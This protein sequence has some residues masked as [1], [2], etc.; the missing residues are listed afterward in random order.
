MDLVAYYMDIFTSDEQA[1]ISQ[2]EDL[3]VGSGA[4]DFR[5]IEHMV[6]V[7][8]PF[9]AIG[10]VRQE[11]RHSNFLSYILD[12]NRPHDF[13]SKFLEEFLAI[14]IEE[15]VD[16][17]L[18][19][20]RLD[21]HFM[22][23]SNVRVLREWQHI[24]ILF[25]LE[26][27]PEMQ[28][29]IVVAVELKIYAGESGNQLNRYKNLIDQTY[30]Q[31]KWDHAFVFLTKDSSPPNEDNQND[32]IPIGLSSVINRLVEI[33]NANKFIGPSSDLFVAYVE[34]LRKHILE[35]ERL[36]ELA[37][38]LWIEHEEALEAIYDHRP[39]MRSDI[40][41]ILSMD[42]QL[43]DKLSNS[44]F[45]LSKDK[46]SRS[47]HRFIVQQWTNIEPMQSGDCTWL[48]SK[49]ILAIELHGSGGL[50]FKI[51]YVIGPGDAD[52]R[53][54]LYSNVLKAVDDGKLKVGRRK[55]IMSKTW[56]HLSS[57]NVFSDKIC[58][59]MTAE[60]S[61]ENIANEII[62]LSNNFL[63]KTLPIYDSIVRGTFDRV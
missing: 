40:F 6:D 15:A 58:N 54:E 31:D 30:D 13:G 38:K 46:S 56:Q 11:I 61:A 35:N 8:C 18:G 45:T 41:D 19:F 26:K 12:P 48:N 52:N 23:L 39:D 21:L 49:N 10:M 17:N 60:E 53:E 16:F 28:K 62:I 55:K 7:F 1:I 37:R 27:M 50:D 20:S 47:Y 51:S 42:T 59:D 22:D 57:D 44:D 33:Q 24:D 63:K 2:I 36:R 9:E 5:K 32:W 29:G 34:M 4:A 43:A 25:E 14:V 3:I